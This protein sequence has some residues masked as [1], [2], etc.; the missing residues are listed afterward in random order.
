MDAVANS[1]SIRAA[2]VYY[3]VPYTTLKSHSNNLISYYHVGRP[4]KF[5]KEEELHLEQAALAL[6][7]YFSLFSMIFITFF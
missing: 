3:N 6:Q 7:G 4:P 5:D 2:F 1:D